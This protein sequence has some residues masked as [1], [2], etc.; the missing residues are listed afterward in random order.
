MATDQKY[1]AEIRSTRDW[2]NIY[3]RDLGFV[4]GFVGGALPFLIIGIIIGL[5]LR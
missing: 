4:I 3:I 5:S 1:R 2:Y